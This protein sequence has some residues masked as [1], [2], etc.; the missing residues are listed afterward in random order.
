MQETKEGYD[1]FQL[2]VIGS[3]AVYMRQQFQAGL[4]H[5]PATCFD[6]APVVA[7]TTTSRQGLAVAVMQLSLHR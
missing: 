3:R 7:K 2:A 5:T 4:N 1:W 6:P